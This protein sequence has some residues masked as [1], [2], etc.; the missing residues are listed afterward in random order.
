M[1]PKKDFMAKNLKICV[2]DL[3]Q[4]YTHKEISN[5]CELGKKGKS[6]VGLIL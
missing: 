5:L 1:D 3:F 2:M 6:F 4:R